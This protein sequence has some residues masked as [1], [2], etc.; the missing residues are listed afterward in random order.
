M[1]MQPTQILLLLLL[2]LSAALC[3]LAQHKN[4]SQQHTV[5][6]PDPT[7]PVF[8]YR[9]R[10]FSWGFQDY[11]Y[12]IT[13]EGT[14]TY[15]D[16]NAIKGK[17]LPVDEQESLQFFEHYKEY[18]DNAK[19][20]KIKPIAPS[21]IN[22]AIHIKNAQLEPGTDV[23]MDGG[24]HLY[25]CIQETDTSRKMLLL[26]ELGQSPRIPKNKDARKVV[27]Y[28]RNALNSPN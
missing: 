4:T 15:I 20:L 1:K 7:E 10:N 18:Q 2:L 8:I 25:Y 3:Y 24:T 17:E 21:I 26:E 16:I 22:K 9:Y 13:P 12:L 6:T 11:A 5:K 23:W 27:E 14:V 28:I 19:H